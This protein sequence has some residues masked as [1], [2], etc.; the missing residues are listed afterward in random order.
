MW[1]EF[2]HYIAVVLGAIL[3][4]GTIILKLEVVIIAEAEEIFEPARCKI[5]VG[6]G[7]V[8]VSIG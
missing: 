5:G 1:E 8:P 4:W 6:L 3:E 7:C 2:F